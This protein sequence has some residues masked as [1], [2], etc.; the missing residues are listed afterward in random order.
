MKRNK[1]ARGSLYTRRCVCAGTGGGSA[2]D[3][4]LKELDHLLED[5]QLYKQVREDLGK[6]YRLTLVHGRHSTSVEV[7]LRPLLIKY[8]Y[9]WSYQE[10]AERA[11]DSLVLRWFCRVYFQPVP[12]KTTL[13]RWTHTL[14]PET[15]HALNDW[16]AQLAAQ[17]KVT[18]G[19]GDGEAA[20]GGGSETSGHPSGGQS[21]RRTASP[22]A[23][24]QMEAGV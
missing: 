24:V 11:A 8:L 23:V 1:H 19:R 10:T 13:I 3:P 7:T 4:V 2:D 6:R 12:N 16:V 9:G 15:L 5:D 14:R 18:K 21:L 20:P 17:V 22:A